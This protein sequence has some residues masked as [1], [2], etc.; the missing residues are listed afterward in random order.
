MLETIALPFKI[1]DF[2]GQYLFPESRKTIHK[3]I[4]KITDHP[5]DAFKYFQHL[6]KTNPKIA[7]DAIEK[8]LIDRN[9]GSLY[10]NLCYLD[11][12]STRNEQKDR[13]WLNTA[14]K[15]NCSKQHMLLYIEMV[16]AKKEEDV[17]KI[18][19][20]ILERN[21]AESLIN[22]FSSKI[23]SK[24]ILPEDRLRQIYKKILE[25]RTIPKKLKRNIK[26]S[27]NLAGITGLK[28][29]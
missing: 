11:Y 9:T 20:N 24:G 12:A 13:E 29:P 4:W 10:S 21:Y 18:A 23:T 6:Y 26:E 25:S 3:I 7:Q 17:K 14:Y 28:S 22:R 2:I 15:N 19:T 8:V 27:F 5:G 16:L 1:L